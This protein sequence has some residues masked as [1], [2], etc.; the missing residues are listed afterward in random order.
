MTIDQVARAAGTTSRNIRAYQTRGLLPPPRVV[1]RVG[2]YDEG[3]LARLRLIA[4]A[5]ARGF[6]L[7]AI[8]ELLEGWQHG[9]SI[10]DV[11]GFEEALTAPWG[12]E[13]E[14]RVEP[15]EL[16]AMFPQTTVSPGVTARAIELGVLVPDGQSFRVP[17]P[18][19]LRIGA[20][21]AS[22]GVPLDTALDVLGALRA[23]TARIA[24]MFVELF[25]R[26]VWDPFREAGMPPDRLPEVTDA[27]R[28][29]RPLASM[30]VG[31]TLANAMEE[32][33]GRA[34]VDRVRLVREAAGASDA[35]A[36]A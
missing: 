24:T 27:L 26:H 10:S 20:E 35:Q 23:D 5:Q 9:K 22:L 36:S 28:R 7:A 11:M 12:D 29:L 1:G 34:A 33:V 18:R 16:Q 31:T 4:G 2:Y 32:T 19:I 8:R 30:A 13:R 3:H 17:S 21:L 14:G 15:E 6:S 25:N